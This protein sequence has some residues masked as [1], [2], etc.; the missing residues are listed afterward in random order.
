[1]LVANKSDLAA[2]VS[3]SDGMAAAH[4]LGIEWIETSAL[5]GS[6]VEEAFHQLV[7]LIPRTKVD[8][9]VSHQLVR[10]ISRL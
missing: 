10:L 6:N 7:R 8:Y 3:R 4:Q 1:M 9:R 5:T 2:A